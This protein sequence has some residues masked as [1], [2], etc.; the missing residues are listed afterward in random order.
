MKKLLLISCLWLLAASMAGAA[1]TAIQ[2][3]DVGGQRAG[4]THYTAD[5]SLG[6]IVGIS[7]VASPL[8]TAR[9]GYIGQLTEVAAFAVLIETNAV[10]E[11]DSQQLSGVVTLDDDTALALDG[12]EVAWDAAVFPLL[13]ISNSG[14]A[15]AT[16]VYEDT[17]A[18]VTGLYLN[19]EGTESFLVRNVNDD[20]F[21]TYAG[22]GLPD[23]WQVGYF[24][25]GSAEA[26]PTN[27]VDEDSADNTAEWVADTVP[28]NSGSYFY[29]TRVVS[30][31]PDAE[32]FF[33]SS[34][35]RLYS[36]EVTTNQAL[37]DWS[38][39]VDQTNQPGVDGELWLTQTNPAVGQY[40]Y[41]VTVAVP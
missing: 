32:I 24:G 4:S 22:D 7:T 33:D 20:D 12:S 36:L 13:S 41:R 10:D 30:A 37:V 1:V 28:T 17:T 31:A 6:G 39:V 2:A 29:L 14:L 9:H 25:I 27:N 34:A 40:F 5:Q 16:N 18:F 21:G 19:I 35:A 8:E 3:V 26:G 23:G 15:T 38:G 11:G